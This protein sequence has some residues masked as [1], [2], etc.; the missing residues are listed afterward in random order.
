[1]RKS[2]TSNDTIAKNVQ[3][4]QKSKYLSKFNFKGLLDKRQSMFNPKSVLFR[5]YTYIL[6][7]PKIL[8]LIFQTLTIEI[9]NATLLCNK[10]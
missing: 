7:C 1:M 5:M 9:R 10:I 8:T 3:V 2:E 4:Y 6:R